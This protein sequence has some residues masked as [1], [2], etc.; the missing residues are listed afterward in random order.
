[1]AKQ[2]RISFP[3]SI[4]QTKESFELIHIDIL[5][6]YHTHS[7]TGAS[8][9]LTLVD[10][11]STATW[12]YLITHKSQSHAILEKLIS[13]VQNQFNKS[14]KTIRSDNSTEFL[15]HSCQSLFDSFGILHHK[16]CPYTPQQNGV[17]ERKNID[18]CYKLP[19]P[20]FS[21]LPT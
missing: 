10:D 8:Y 11:F 21:G 18:T 1:M 4:I 9:F 12:T 16:T 7:I 14:V 3:K 6:H 5:G 17:V 20:P 15:S 19:G 2:T 13:I